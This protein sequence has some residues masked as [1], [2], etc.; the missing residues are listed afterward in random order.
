MDLAA[1]TVWRIDFQHRRCSRDGLEDEQ[2]DQAHIAQSSADCTHGRVKQLR[3]DGAKRIDLKWLL[4]EAECRRPVSGAGKRT[5]VFR[6][7]DEDT[8]VRRSKFQTIEEA[9]C[10]AVPGVDVDNQNLR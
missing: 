9:D 10:T 7:D 4:H 8:Q 2:V 6:A 1:T 3:H 5:R